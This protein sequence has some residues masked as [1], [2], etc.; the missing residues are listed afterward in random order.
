MLK[1]LVAIGL[2]I[3]GL[4]TADLMQLNGYGAIL[5]AIYLAVFLPMFVIEVIRSRR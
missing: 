4:I 3:I 1:T 5:G 2:I